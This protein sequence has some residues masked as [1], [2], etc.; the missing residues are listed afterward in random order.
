M[1]MTG[2]DIV[3]FVVGAVLFG[4]AT[5]AIV[6]MDGGLGGTG[7]A[8]SQF[9][10]TWSAK[11]T[12]VGSADVGSV[13]DAETSFDVATEGVTT[14]TVVVACSDP[15]PGP[16]AFNVQIAVEGPNGLTGEGSGACNGEISIP[17]EVDAAPS[18]TIVRGSLESEARE[19]LP[20]SENATRAV[21]TWT[22]SVSGGRAG[23]LPGLPGT[24]PS[25]TITLTVETYEA[26][27]SPIQK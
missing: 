18:D 16:G 13:R 14:V 24:D 12:E 5:Y 6:N 27:L 19:N 4:G 9:T 7:S 17:V 22:V 26:R 3:L 20:V 23:G 10:V 11:E 21:G 15:V 8:L 25:G 2:P 1:R